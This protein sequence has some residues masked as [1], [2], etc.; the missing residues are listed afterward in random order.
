MIEKNYFIGG[1]RLRIASERPIDDADFFPLFRTD[2]T[3]APDI[4]VNVHQGGLPALQ[5]AQARGAEHHR[6]VVKDGAEYYYTF[7]TD[8][9]RKK[10]LPYA[11]A[12]RQGPII[13]LHVDY[14]PPFWDTMIFDAVN[15]ADLFLEQSAA[16]LHAACIEVND[17]AIL[18]AGP[19]QQGKSTQARL[20]A[21]ERGAEIINGDRILIRETG[22]GFF[23]FGV[24]F[25]GSSRICLNRKLPV[26][27]VVFPEKGPDNA[28]FQLPAIDAFKRIIGCITYSEDDP[29]VQERAIRF[30]EQLAMKSRCLRLVC[31]PD[32][33]AVQTLE[34]VLYGKQLSKNASSQ[35]DNGI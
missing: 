1:L 7:F 9:I 2:V 27:A 17:E 28:V 11:C 33:A 31:T 34:K 19:K 3:L 35:P 32:P 26:R 12:V 15:A 16:I 23:A 24:P 21:N 8:T 13:M 30:A 4:T 18:F 14:D 29:A 6:R 22:D 10:V 25:C 5:A 20:W